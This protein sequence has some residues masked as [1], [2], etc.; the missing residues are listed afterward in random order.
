[1]HMPTLEIQNLTLSLRD[2]KLCQSLSLSAR[3]GDVVG[4]LGPNGSGKTTLLH[5]LVRLHT[6]DTGIIK[7][8]SQT[9]T[10]F[11]SKKLAREIGILFQENF[12]NF[13]LSVAEF[14][15]AARYPHRRLFSRESDL[16]HRLVQEALALM[17]LENM[18]QQSVLTLSGG[19]RRR[20]NIAALLAQR[21][22]IYLLDEPTNHLDWRHQI[23]VLEHFKQISLLQPAIVL[24]ALHD[25]NQAQ[26]YCNKIL[27]LFTDGSHLFGPAGEVMTSK[28]LSAL[29]SH[30]VYSVK[31]QEARWWCVN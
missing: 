4:I 15:L 8:N 14:C 12:F 26:R 5:S 2:K 29:Y 30:A 16:D 28:N 11:K 17:E 7:I 23:Q 18:S 25:V 6:P 19:E 1:M 9:L 21:P 24:M 22:H 13:P 27:M 31:T 10:T 3:A 20:L